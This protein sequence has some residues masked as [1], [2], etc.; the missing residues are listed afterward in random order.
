MVF[1]DVNVSPDIHF[2]VEAIF[3]FLWSSWVFK[4][5]QLLFFETFY[6]QTLWSFLVSGFWL[7]K[8]HRRSGCFKSS[9]RHKLL[10]PSLQ[11]ATDPCW[12]LGRGCLDDLQNAQPSGKDT[13]AWTFV[14][15]PLA[16]PI[17]YHYT[18]IRSWYGYDACITCFGRKPG[19]LHVRLSPRQQKH[20][21]NSCSILNP[22]P[23]FHDP[24]Q[25]ARIGRFTV[26]KDLG[27]CSCGSKSCTVQSTRTVWHVMITCL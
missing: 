7:P 27:I 8:E 22:L 6:W 11:H 26:D 25:G 20:G 16:H 13:A 24:D 17:P 10:R 19:S 9:V 23:N 5:F 3:E 18:R 21:S 2:P 12:L 14:I 1:V 4:T 15:K